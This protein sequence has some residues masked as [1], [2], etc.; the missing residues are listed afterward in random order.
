MTDESLGGLKLINQKKNYTKFSLLNQENMQMLLE[1][2]RKD[3]L[4]T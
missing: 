1:T 3:K 4:Y 2:C